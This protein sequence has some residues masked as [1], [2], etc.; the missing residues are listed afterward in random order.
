MRSL[1]DVITRL[2][3]IEVTLIIISGS[4]KQLWTSYILDS[5]RQF[6]KPSRGYCMGN[7]VVGTLRLRYIVSWIHLEVHDL[8]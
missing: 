5:T 2:D 1:S 8:Q 3:I 6:R 7:C 4:F